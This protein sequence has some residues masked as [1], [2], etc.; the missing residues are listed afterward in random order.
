MSTHSCTKRYSYGTSTVNCPG[1]SIEITPP[2][3]HIHLAELLRAGKL[4][5]N[6]VGAPTT[7]GATVTGI[8]GIGVNTPRAAAVAATTIG[9]A[10]ELHI[11]NG[12]IL[13]IGAKC[14]IVAAKGP[15]TIVGGPCGMTI[16]ELGETPKLHF[17]I[18]PI[19]TC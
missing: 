1:I 4:L 9:L 13:T 12:G 16:N 3:A 2:Q 10:I 11:P 17:I 19:T 14:I 5:I 7:Q 15:P 8:Q 18:A 6:T